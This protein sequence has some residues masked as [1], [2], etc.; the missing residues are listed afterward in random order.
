MD[1]FIEKQGAEWVFV[2]K[3]PEEPRDFLRNLSI[4]MGLSASK[5]AKD[6]KA[7]KSGNGSDGRYT[8][9]GKIRHFEYLT[10]FSE[11]G[12]ERVNNHLKKPA[13]K[14]SIA[15]LDT[16]VMADTMA[17]E[18]LG[19][20]MSATLSSLTTLG[21]FKNAIEKDESAFNFDIMDFHL[22]CVR[23]LSS[24]QMHCLQHAPHDFPVFAYGYGLGMNAVINEMLSH[25]GTSP[26][27]NRLMFPDAVDI[28]RQIIEHEGGATLE[29]AAVREKDIK[30]QQT[31]SQSQV[32]PSFENP[33]EDWMDLEFRNRFSTIMFGEE[34]GNVRMP[35]GPR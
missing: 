19:L 11:L 5:F 3:R 4:A 35:F 31:E 28:L 30:L 9:V 24:I 25:C 20:D 34:H 22:R 26:H 8:V 12:H 13:L 2:G 23:L 16:I 7:P 27:L 18:S 32:E 21:A 17:R 33:H 1:Y 10:R 15:G 6:Y 29:E 14:L